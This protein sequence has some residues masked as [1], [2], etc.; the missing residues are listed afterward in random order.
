MTSRP[1]VVIKSKFIAGSEGGTSFN[2][3][4]NYMDR[5]E[6]HDKANA[7]EKYQ[8]YMSNE[9]KS[10]GLFTL[11]RDSLNDADKDFFKEEFKKAQESGSV[12]WQDVISF[13]NDWLKESG[14]LEGKNID[15]KQIQE[16][17]R[18][19]VQDML[20]KEGMIDSA[21]WTGAIHY[22]TDNI[23][24]HV[25]IVQ[26]KD[27]K[28]RGKR[29]QASID[30]M[31]SKVANKIK[32]RSKHNEKL[33]VF[34]RERVINSKRDDPFNRLKNQIMNPDLV[35]QF[36]E[37]HKQLPEDKRMWRYNMKAIEDVRPEID[38]LTTMYIEKHFKEEFKDFRQQ[39]EREVEIHKRMYGNSEKSENYRDTKMKDLYTRMG[40]TILKEVSE[41]DSKQKEIA[42]KN[43]KPCKLIVQRDLNKAVYLVSRYAKDDLEKVKNQKA[44]EELQ[45]EQEYERT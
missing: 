35:R 22:N 16:A 7:F 10:T 40:N 21:I 5:A 11:S 30:S 23:H 37:I 28:E 2:D 33:N 17:T 19:A 45:K 32:D 31:K 3:Y 9:E 4:L 20:K 24:V 39:L 43:K 26:T 18:S 14:V 36:K 8:D 44:Y 15:N 27:F 41:Y 38:K 13:D 1:A 29:K 25:A 42:R 6:T 34:I 12:L